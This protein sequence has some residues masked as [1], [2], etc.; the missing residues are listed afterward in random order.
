LI[1]GINFKETLSRDSFNELCKDIFNKMLSVVKQALD[2]S[3]IA[4]S[5]IQEIIMVGGSTQIPKVKE[6]VQ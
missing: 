6:L 1:D 2:Q 3:E 4:K 5:D